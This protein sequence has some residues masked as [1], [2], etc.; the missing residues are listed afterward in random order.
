LPSF[1][2]SPPRHNPGERVAAVA[3]MRRHIEE[4]VRSHGADRTSAKL[5][6]CCDSSRTP[7]HV[8]T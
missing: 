2:S 4:E 8:S 1:M 5:R 6:L 7:G 3:R